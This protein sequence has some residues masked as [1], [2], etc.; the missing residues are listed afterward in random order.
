MPDECDELVT[1]LSL[2]SWRLLTMCLFRLGT[3]HSLLNQ[4][5]TLNMIKIKSKLC[6]LVLTAGSL[7]I[8]AGAANAQNAN[9][10]PGDLVLFFQ[11]E[12]NTNTLY[13]NLGASTTY[14]G[15]A[16]GPDV[17]NILNIINI[18]TQLNEAFG[19][20]WASDT[21]L[22]AGIAGV[23]GTSSTNVGLSSGDPH[24]TLYVSASRT[25]VGT[26]GSAESSGYTV[27][28]DSGMSNGANGITA[29][30][31]VLETQYTTAAT[32][33][34]TSVSTIDD[35]NPISAGLQGAGFS[36]FGAGVQQQGTAGVFA[37]NFG[38]AGSTEFA[39]DLFRIQARNNI[40]GQV[41]NGET[42][43]L[44]TYEGTFTVG[45]DGSV[46]FTAVPEPSTYALIALTGILYFFVNKR[47]KLNS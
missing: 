23:W 31:N 21:S 14:R 28:T 19:A 38:D 18:N 12:G 37:S 32:V 7:A 22:Y 27:N 34:P 13:A 45:T 6:A 33:S 5:N 20:S 24:R 26:I 3:L 47:R 11:K 30:N 16:T 36:I 2:A 35:Q 8:S 43:R 39:L 9:Y 10:A 25:A 44:G 17:A 4:T 41:G 15:S 29:M 1:I 46:S 42:N 40:S